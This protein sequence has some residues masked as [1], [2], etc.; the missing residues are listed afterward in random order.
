MSVTGYARKWFSLPS[1]LALLLGIGAISATGAKAAAPLDQADQPT[2]VPQQSVK[3]FG[4]L[5]VWSDGGRVY[6]SEA[7]GEARELQLGDTTEARHL[8]ALLERDGAVEEAP[9]V[10]QHRIVLV[11]GGGDGFH[12]APGGRPDASTAPKPAVSTGDRGRDPAGPA[13]TPHD[14]AA[15]PGKARTPP[16]NG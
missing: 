1:R 15:Q 9:Q 8:R 11:G 7:G 2:R 3:V 14:N 10:L 13:P 5:R 6:L 16:Q 12:W 4:E